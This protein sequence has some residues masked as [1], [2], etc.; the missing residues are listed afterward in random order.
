MGSPIRD[1]ESIIRAFQETGYVKIEGLLS[2]ERV[3]RLNRAIDRI[4]AEEPASLRYDIRNAVSRHPDIADLMDDEAVLPILANTL[5]Y[6]IQLSLSHLTVRHPD[7]DAAEPP[8]TK[9]SVG[10]HQDG[11]VPG[12]P[13]VNGVT[14]LFYMKICY[15]LSDMSEPNRGNTKLVPGSGN[16][17]YTPRRQE[18][19]TESLVGEVQMC[20]KPGDAFLFAQNVW[21]AAAPNLSPM[22]RR[23]LFMGYSYLWMRPLDYHT[24]APHQLEGASPLRRQMLGQLDD[25]PFNYFVVTKRQPE[26]PLKLFVAATR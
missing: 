18:G 24:V 6:N 12:F 5:G 14:P 2:R 9:N 7:P 21:H 11:P 23:Q 15:F 22:S 3:E 13:S 16:A 17:P 19:S 20:G 8:S 10:W 4:I 1:Y 26:L 25:E